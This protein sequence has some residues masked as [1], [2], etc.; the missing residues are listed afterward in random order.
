MTRTVYLENWHD[1]IN[2]TIDS[3]LLAAGQS[4]SN[5][6]DRETL[7]AER[8][9][10]LEMVRQVRDVAPSER[11]RIGSPLLHASVHDAMTVPDQIL[12][13]VGEIHDIYRRFRDRLTWPD[14]LDCPC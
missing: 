9:V 3:L 14:T 13:L 10:I 4:G 12:N 11:E 8:N 6:A 2:P 1:W 7:I 5:T